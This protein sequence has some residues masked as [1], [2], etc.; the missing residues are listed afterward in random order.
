MRE[1]DKTALGDA[2][3]NTP[4]SAFPIRGRKTSLSLLKSIKPMR[5]P[6]Y[7]LT[8]C[9]NAAA[10]INRT[11]WAIVSQQGE[12]AIRY[13][14]QDGGSTDG[15]LEI[16][17]GWERRLRD[18]RE[19]L[20]MRVE[21]TYASERDTGMYDGI[22]AG[23]RRMDV[24]SDA[25][26][27]WCNADDTVWQGAVAC[28]QEIDRCF[29]EVEW[30]MGW[31]TGFDVSGRCESIE[32]QPFFPRQ[33]LANGMADGSHWPYLQQESTFWRKRL[34]NRVGGVDRELK[35]AGDW[36]LWRR[37]AQTQELVLVDRQL[38]SFHARPGQKSADV[39]GYRGECER[40]LP[41]AERLA[42]FDRVTQSTQDW[43]VRRI[44]VTPTGELRLRHDKVDL[45]PFDRLKAKFRPREYLL[46]KLM[47]GHHAARQ[48]G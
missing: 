25:L 9:L 13:H 16:L 24:P 33:I 42:N 14:V 12:G 31:P 39:A 30:V 2:K 29:P 32:R 5:K 20:P 17:A 45:K 40:L 26:M 18:Q 27:G 28:L 15:T 1:A 11:I 22:D 23:F 10:T 46:R 4:A 6:I 38:G 37:F 19:L 21:F 3:E 34:W 43:S 7:L 35:L 48:R 47:Q 36:D 8:P 44:G 41:T